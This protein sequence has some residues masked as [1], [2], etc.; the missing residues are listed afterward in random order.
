MSE[1]LPITSPP[2]RRAVGG[3]AHDQQHSGH[4]HAVGGGATH[5]GGD[6]C[7]NTPNL[8]RKIEAYHQHVLDGGSQSAKSSP[9]P[10]RRLDKL[11]GCIRDKPSPLALR[12]R[13]FEMASAGAGASGGGCDFPPSAVR[14][15]ASNSLGSAQLQQLMS[16]CQ[17]QQQ[18]QQHNHQQHLH[19]LRQA[20]QQLHGH[21]HHHH[22][23]HQNQQQQQQQ[24]IESPLMRRRV[25][26]DCGAYGSPG[27]PQ[28][29]RRQAVLGEPGCFS[30]PIH[31]P[32]RPSP[33][34]FG[35]GVSG[36]GGGSA[37]G[38]LTAGDEAA[39]SLPSSAFASPARSI[40]SVVSTIADCSADGG[41]MG[42]CGSGIDDG[43]VDEM[44]LQAAA[45]ATAAAA[46]ATGASTSAEMEQPLQ[47]TDQTVVSGWLKFRDNKRV[48]ERIVCVCLFV[49]FFSRFVALI[50]DVTW[51]WYYTTLTICVN[52]AWNISE[53]TYNE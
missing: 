23:L 27:S 9:L 12:S 41:D 13:R 1:S 10:H 16:A 21:H 33:I 15:A 4:G 53:P 7:K 31:Q 46:A 32:R 47:G 52:H 49:G 24:H 35:V 38:R 6:S 34:G 3:A 25:D 28:I 29:S 11:E 37:R 30:S 18:Q 39:T 26:S 45:A 2:R 50:H 42:G 19:R 48:C 14:S 36:G 51:T 8:S 44:M 17:Q 5:C 20:E 43:S 40:S 22:Q